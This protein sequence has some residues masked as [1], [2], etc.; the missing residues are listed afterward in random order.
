MMPAHLRESS[1]R[2]SGILSGENSQLI[3]F[4]EIAGDLFA[5]HELH[6][7]FQTAV[8]VVEKALPGG[9]E[10][11]TA[12]WRISV[13]VKGCAHLFLYFSVRSRYV[14]ASTLKTA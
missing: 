8:R 9:Q 13:L 7:Q 6:G 2:R 3:A 4:K 5:R 12:W 1:P 10:F 14:S 11:P